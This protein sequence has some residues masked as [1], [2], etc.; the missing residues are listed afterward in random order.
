MLQAISIYTQGDGQ[1]WN[2][3]KMFEVM[4]EAARTSLKVLGSSLFNQIV[5][6]NNVKKSD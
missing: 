4:L 2:L 3:N 5:G 1:R 6:K